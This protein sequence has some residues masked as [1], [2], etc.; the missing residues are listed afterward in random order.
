M[1]NHESDVVN[2]QDEKQ[3]PER[4]SDTYEK[5]VWQALQPWE[6]VWGPGVTA[7]L[8]QAAG[9]TVESL[10]SVRS[11]PKIIL[12]VEPKD[13]EPHVYLLALLVSES[14]Q[15][16]EGDLD[17]VFGIGEPRPWRA[18]VF[19]RALNLEV[20]KIKT[21]GEVIERFSPGSQFLGVVDRIKASGKNLSTIPR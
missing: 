6:E 8:S 21:P 11:V 10:L 5:Q 1:A 9:V 7:N 4:P 18:R 2:D 19:T 20:L 16:W 13:K 14:P 17:T 12:Y 15:Q 3:E